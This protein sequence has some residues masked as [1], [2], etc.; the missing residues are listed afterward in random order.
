MNI[1]VIPPKNCD[2]SNIRHEFKKL[3]NGFV[4]IETYP[5][6]VELVFTYINGSGSIESSKPLIKID[7]CTYQVPD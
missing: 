7:D 2:P 6:G 1:T 5:N 3:Q 4:D